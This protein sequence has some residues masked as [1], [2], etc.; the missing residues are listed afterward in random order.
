M[1]KFDSFGY[2]TN[3]KGNDS[4]YVKDEYEN[5]HSIKESDDFFG[6]L[7][8]KVRF[9]L[10]NCG[11]RFH[12]KGDDPVYA[13][14][15]AGYIETVTVENLREH[16]ALYTCFEALVQYVA[17]MLDEHSGEFELGD[18]VFDEYSSVDDLLKIITPTG[19]AFERSEYV[20]EEECPIAFSIKFSFVPVPD[21]IMEIALHGDEPIYVGEYLGVS[22]W[23]DKLLK[24]K[25][26]YLKGR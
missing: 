16:T 15:C 9:P 17:D 12:V 21:E 19:L 22:P 13:R 4:F 1:C 5:D 2:T 26:N 24:K 14:R 20:P 8:G 11:I 7:E 3:N 25:Y 10:F 23:N 18:F 6:R